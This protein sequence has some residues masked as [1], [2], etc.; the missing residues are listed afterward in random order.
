[1]QR[2]KPLIPLLLLLAFTLFRLGGA[3]CLDATRDLRLGT[4]GADTA[5]LQAALKAGTRSIYFPKGVYK[6]GTLELPENTRLVFSPEAQIEV[7][8][9]KLRSV[10]GWEGRAITALFVLKGNN[11]AI[12][13][14][15]AAG[16]FRNADS[17]GT[18]ACPY[19]VYGKNC[20]KLRFLRLDIDF[21]PH[22]DKTPVWEIADK[23]PNGIFL[24][25]CSDIVFAD[26][27]IRGINHGLQTYFCSNVT[28]SG[29]VGF[30]SSTIVNFGY[31]SKGLKYCGNWSRKL[32]Y[33]CIFRGGSPDPSRVAAIPQGSSA[34]VLRNLPYEESDLAG[35]RKA[36]AAAGAERVATDEKSELRHL[37]GVYDIQITD[38]YA[39]YGRTLAWGNRARQVIFANNVSR[40]MTDYSYG[41]EG[42]ENVVFAN[43]ISINAR[44]YSIMTMY[45]ADKITVTNNQCIVRNE[46]YEQKYSDFPEQSAYWGGLLRFHHGPESKSDREAGSRYGAG[47]VLVCGN[48]FVNEAGERV[49]GIVID[50]DQ[51][52]FTISGNKFVNADISKKKG[53]GDLKILGNDFTSALALPHPF[54]LFKGTGEL[55]CRD[56]VM[57]YSGGFTATEAARK[58]Y[59]AQDEAQGPGAEENLQQP[60]PAVIVGNRWMTPSVAVLENNRIEGWNN[61]VAVSVGS[62][63]RPA[64]CRLL[65]RNNTVGGT[66]LVSGTA[67][68]FIDRVDGNLDAVTLQAA[69]TERKEYP[70]AKAKK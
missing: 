66:I 60:Y 58:T 48:L 7:D 27:R 4:G 15:H 17:T 36:L 39:E 67:K 50:E 38:N 34:V 11:I 53:A 56:N 69:R 52:D 57:R 42:C 63:S 40:F 20:D 41:V 45:W 47:Q 24:E 13:G 54:L 5:P 28:V 26:S 44:S 9:A 65:V 51:R 12:E 29:N 16:V 64:P 14:L 18:L 43:N 59:D 49:R 1:M 31:G 23:V 37:F 10:T 62:G 30:N 19:L 3:E 68:D 33:P 25:N 46:P 22:T 32:R 70:P 21:P 2:Q 8:A 55:I 35:V 61:D 6:F